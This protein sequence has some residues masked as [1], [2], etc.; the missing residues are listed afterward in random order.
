MTLSPPPAAR[1]GDPL[2]A[3]ATPSLLLDLEAFEANL[4]AM[5]AFAAHHDVA[6]RPHAKA[7]KSS[8]IAKRQIEAGAVGVCCQKLSEAYPFAAAGI[9]SI[10]VSNEFAGADKLAMAVELASHVQLSVCVDALPQVQALGHAA[11]EAG[12]TI[13]VL[14]EVDA[15]QQRCG[16]TGED[17]LL[18]LVDAIA[19]QRA[20]RFAGIQA[21]H[22]GIQHVADWNARR[23]AAGRA[24]DSAAG[25][26]RALDARGVRCG[27]VTGG[28]TGTVEFDAASGVFTE[29]QPG[30]YLFMDGDYGGIGWEGALQWRHSLFVL[31]TVMSATR[32]GMAVCDVGLKGLAVDS[33]LPRSVHWLDGRSAPVLSYIAANDEHGMLH[34]K[35]HPN[36]DF[37]PL[38]GER[39]LLPPGHCDPSVN[40]YDE[41]VCYRGGRVVDLWP[42]DAR[43]LSR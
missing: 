7:H 21:Y 6:L 28:G 36:D 1:T 22:G 38:V 26:V 10:H 11:A 5:A 24:A 3:V 15:G 12:V 19:A 14:P 2:T 27:V 42:I 30:S 35:D 20:L 9:R 29:L 18:E 34:A 40:L 33:G 37:G 25:Y 39:L 16:V 31:S 41:Y 8:E 32:P 23:T 43:G 4:A 13:D 17:A